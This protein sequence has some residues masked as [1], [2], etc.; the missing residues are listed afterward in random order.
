MVKVDCM[1]ASL[2]AASCLASTGLFLQAVSNTAALP[3]EVWE[4]IVSNLG[5]AALHQASFVSKD[6]RKLACNIFKAI[7]CFE[8]KEQPY[9]NYT[10]LLYEHDRLVLNAA[11][12]CGVAEANLI[13][14]S[15]LDYSYIQSLLEAQFGYCIR[16]G[17][18]CLPKFELHELSLSILNDMQKI[19]VLPYALDQNISD[20][21][22]TYFIC[23]LVELGRWELLEQMRFPKI[24]HGSFS[25]LM[26]MAVPESVIAAAAKSLALNNSGS[27]LS[28]LFS[29]GGFGIQIASFP[30]QCSVHLCVVQFLHEKGIQVTGGWILIDGLERSSI[31]FWM[32]LLRQK[33]A[34]AKR[35][36]KLVLKHGDTKTM[37]LMSAFK[38]PMMTD[39]ISFSERKVYNAMLIHFRFSALCNQH[40]IR[41]YN[42][43]LA[44]GSQ[45]NYH[46]IC[47]FLN[48]GQDK[49]ASERLN[50][51]LGWAAS[52]AVIERAYR[53]TGRSMAI[54]YTK[55]GEVFSGAPKLLKRLLKRN[56]KDP[57][58][59][60]V[61]SSIQSTSRTRRVDDYG[62]LAPLAALKRLLYEQS[63]SIADVTE[64]LSM[65]DGFECNGKKVS[66][67]LHVL[68]TVMFWEAA[69]NVMAHFLDQVPE[70]CRLD[71]DFI[72]GLLLTRKYSKEFCE[73]LLW[74]VREAGSYWDKMVREYRPDLAGTLD[75]IANSPKS[76][77][78]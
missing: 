50:M 27:L 59:R 73:K 35:L 70:T 49:R 57:R 39:G 15:S 47:A 56:V 1:L 6:L 48:H 36:R 67:E 19:S 40:I 10:R 42:L 61:W 8:Y 45:A 5:F 69:E 72:W 16:F 58:A 76:T 65:L 23:G 31:R 29:L 51:V 12:G 11:E 46:S 21:G 66:Q 22:W 62:C 38:R 4:T 55:Y 3:K 75:L 18:N 71:C 54:L 13:L 17:Q 25:K 34:E 7:Y 64:M 30:E 32:Y 26:A 60:L 68:Y 20:P 37:H 77:A 41:N 63:I 78:T 14:Q 44:E 53:I 74:H 24:G 9:L 28:K 52:E 43:M 2:I 33:D